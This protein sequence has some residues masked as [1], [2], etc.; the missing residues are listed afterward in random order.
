M[1]NGS[2]HDTKLYINDKEW[3]TVPRLYRVVYAKFHLEFWFL[4]GSLRDQP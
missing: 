1:V 3:L 4:L 2:I